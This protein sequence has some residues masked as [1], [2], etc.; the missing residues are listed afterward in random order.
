MAE[1]GSFEFVLTMK[2]VMRPETMASVVRPKIHATSSTIACR[3]Q[4]LFRPWT[5]LSH[6]NHVAQI[7][8]VVGQTEARYDGVTGDADV[9]HAAHEVRNDERA[10]LEFHPVGGSCHVRCHVHASRWSCAGSTGC[11]HAVNGRRA[12]RR[13]YIQPDALDTVANLKS[14]VIVRKRKI[15]V[16]P[17]SV[18][19]LISEDERRARVGR[20]RSVTAE[21]KMQD[22]IHEVE[23]ETGPDAVSVGEQSVRKRRAKLHRQRILVTRV[24]HDE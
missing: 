13:S 17:E 8:S 4:T 18:V 2:S 12:G 3:R 21:L 24:T 9:L 1:R 14:D 15:Q 16:P 7:A 11:C 23:Q 19:D 22:A 10:D 5:S 20:Y 6:V